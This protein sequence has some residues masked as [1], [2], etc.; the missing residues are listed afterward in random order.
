[1]S[2]LRLIEIENVQQL[3]GRAAAWDD[4]WQ[5]SEVALP[6]CR[7]EPLALWLEQFAADDRFTALAIE[8]EGQLVAALP[9]VKSRKRGVAVLELA[10]NCWAESGDLLLDPEAAA[11]ADDLLDLLLRGVRKIGVPLLWL[12]GVPAGEDRWRDFRAA[13]ARAHR[14]P[15]LREQYHVGVVEIDHDWQAYQK[16][17]SGSH[18]AAV[19][20]GMRRLSELGEFE[21]VQHRQPEANQVEP[22]LLAAFAIEDKSWKGEAGTS[23][24]QTPGMTG[25][26][27][28]QAHDLIAHDQWQLDMLLLDGAPIAFEMC[29]RGKGTLYSHKIGYDAEYAQ[30]SPGRT[31]RALQLE[32]AFADPALTSLDTMGIFDRS[33]GDWSNRYYTVSRLVAPTGALG[34]RP[35][36]AAYSQLGQLK[37]R[38]RGEE[39]TLETPRLGAVKKVKKTKQ[40]KQPA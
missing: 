33:K 11:D 19:R 22:L 23:I 12:D 30:C 31:L 25:F 29:Y 37:R 35:L 36:T 38:L 13:L 16:A 39:T 9:L 2:S 18:R 14:Q 34:G 27:V 5:R 4:L 8:C 32:A 24:L 28:Q 15:V 10:S 3:R 7:A 17:W 21:L 26:F 20:R 40:D 1:M 6:T